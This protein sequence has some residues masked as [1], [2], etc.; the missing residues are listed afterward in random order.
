MR[1]SSARAASG[2]ASASNWLRSC[3][4]AAN[5]RLHPAPRAANRPAPH[6]VRRGEPGR[7]SRRNPGRPVAPVAWPRTRPPPARC[8]ARGGRTARTRRCTAR[9]GA[10]SAADWPARP[11]AGRARAPPPPARSRNPKR[12][13]RDRAR[14]RRPRR[15][16]PARDGWPALSS[17]QS[18]RLRPAADAPAPGHRRR[19]VPAALQQRT[20]IRGMSGA[21]PLAMD[22]QCFRAVCAGVAGTP[23]GGFQCGRVQQQVAGHVGRGRHLHAGHD[24][25]GGTHHC[26]RLFR[27]ALQA[28]RGAQLV[29]GVGDI[30]GATVADPLPDRQRAARDRLGLRVAAG[31]VQR[32]GIVVQHQRDV[33]MTWRQRLFGIGR[34]LASLLDRA[35]QF[36]GLAQRHHPAGPFAHGLVR[37]AVLGAQ[38][39]GHRLAQCG[40]RG[41][42]VAAL[43]MQH[44]QFAHGACVGVGVLAHRAGVGGHQLFEQ[45]AGFVVAAGGDQHRCLVAQ[46]LQALR[47]VLQAAGATFGEDGVLHRQHL[48]EAAQLEQRADAQLAQQQP[49]V[50]AH[51]R[52]LVHLRLQGI[53]P[54][55]RALRVAGDIGVVEDA[56]L[57]GQ[58]RCRRLAGRRLPRRQQHSHRHDPRGRPQH[59]SCVFP[60]DRNCHLRA[61]LTPAR[62]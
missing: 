22:G 56:D 31:H 46:G 28:Q 3:R 47:V 16:Q 26:Q 54:G 49:V 51:G 38:A 13:P 59:P 53:D 12:R 25:V 30:G 60:H 10:W 45:G 50:L 6:P 8:P 7:P 33:R 27:L 4:S 58:R 61:P 34:G 15:W 18:P 20:R 37:H 48:V 32:A 17:R 40:G 9:P 44:A 42:D 62:R 43:E 29:E 52:V 2:L 55:Q 36:A 11:A 39:M 23:D 35:R 57:R 21:H 14:C 19:P 24:V 41:R 1:G 5:A